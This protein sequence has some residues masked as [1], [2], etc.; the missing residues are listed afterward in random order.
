MSHRI[1]AVVPALSLILMAAPPAMAQAV[2]ASTKAGPEAGPSAEE[3]AAI[4]AATA[5][6][7]DVSVALAEGYVLHPLCVVAE[8]EGQPAQLG[9]MGYHYFRPDLLGITAE[10]PRVDGNGTHTDWLQPAILL[11]EPQADGSLELTAIENLVWAKAWHEAGNEGPPEFH[12]QQYYYMID[13][14]E[15]PVDEAHG[16][17]P[18]YELHW[19]L[20]RE[21]PAG[22]FMPFNV[23]VN[24]ANATEE[25]AM[26]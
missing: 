4:E 22:A 14:P 15:T 2:N 10:Q 21:N 24:C 3:V 9:G 18:H 6:Y 7:G 20:Y 26:H 19:W 8:T 16:F 25:H 17:E 23:A 13:N 5:K 12:G 11:Y 1:A